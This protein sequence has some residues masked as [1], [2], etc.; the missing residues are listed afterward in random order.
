MSRLFDGEPQRAI[1]PLA[2]ALRLNP[3]DPQNL[4]WFNLLAYAQLL[5]GEPGN[6]LESA[7][8]A[9]TVRPVFRPTFEVLACCAVALGQLDDARIW[10][11]RVKSLDGPASHFIAPLRRNHADC[12][13]QIARM[14]NMA[15]A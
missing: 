5:A 11:A 7:N 6:A 14:L 2:H 15:G 13:A 4:V 1:V 3:N 8:R 12:D 9:L 10:A